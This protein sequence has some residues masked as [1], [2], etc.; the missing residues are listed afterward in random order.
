MLATVLV[1]GLAQVLAPAVSFMI[2]AQPHC[3]TLRQEPLIP[4]IIFVVCTVGIVWMLYPAGFG[5]D[6]L[7]QRHLPFKFRIEL[8]IYMTAYAVVLIIGMKVLRRCVASL[9]QRRRRKVSADFY[10]PTDT[11]R[12]GSS[13]PP[14]RR[15]FDGRD[16]VLRSTGSSDVGAWLRR[17]A[18]AI[19]DVATALPAGRSNNKVA[20]GQPSA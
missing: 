11:N 4:F 16:A 2:D 10:V 3:L 14:G 1:I 8:L 20:Q 19:T 13:V 17:T 15:S 6:L 9:H 7:R 5:G 18:S 12:P